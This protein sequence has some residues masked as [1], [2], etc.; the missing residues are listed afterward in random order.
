MPKKKPNRH[1][2]VR[3]GYRRL[4]LNFYILDMLL[5]SFVLAS[6]YYIFIND[7]EDIWHY[8]IVNRKFITLY[9]WAFLVSMISSVISRLIVG[10]EKDIF[11]IKKIVITL[12][13]ALF[14]SIMLY[15]G[16]VSYIFEEYNF[17]TILLSVGLLKIFNMLISNAI[18]DILI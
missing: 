3:R 1:L 14:T 5:Y 16:I 4:S 10:N 15:A 13:T 18:G 7:V 9:I 12:F 8:G 11:S 6:V 2:S 17:S